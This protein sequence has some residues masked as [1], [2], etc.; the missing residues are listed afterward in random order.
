VDRKQKYVYDKDICKESGGNAYEKQWCVDAHFFPAVPLW[1]WYHGKRSKKVCRFFEK[2][3]AEILADSA[4]LSDQLW[5]FTVPVVF[6]FCG[7]SIFY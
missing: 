1:D 5:G 2:V 7:K 4:D 3:R 6:Q